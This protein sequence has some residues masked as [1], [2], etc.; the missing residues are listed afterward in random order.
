MKT[1]FKTL[2]SLIFISTSAIAQPETYT[3]QQSIELALTNNLQLKQTDLQAQ[4][5]TVN[6]KQ[7]RANLLP[8]VSA[9][10]GHGSNQGRSID[11]FTNAYA[12]K[13]IDYANY[14]LNG[15]ITLFSGLILRNQL[16]QNS[17]ALEASKMDLQQAKENLALDVILAY[18]QILNNQ[19]QLNQ[20]ELQVDVTS[21]QVERSKLLSKE[22]VIAPAQLSDLMGQL[23]ND[24]LSVINSRNRFDASRI[25][26]AGLMNVE[27]NRDFK[28]EPLSPDALKPADYIGPD[29]IY[30]LALQQLA[31]IR[32]A[33][34]R[35]ESAKKAVHAARGNLYPQI[36][37]N[38]N[39]FSNYSSAAQTS[40]MISSEDLPGSDYVELNGNKL[41]VISTQRS[42]E[43]RRIAYNSQIR[44]NYSSSVSIG[45]RMPLFN[46]SRVRNQISLAKIDLNST[47]LTEESTRLQLK[48]AVDLAWF[49]I[50]ASSN[51]VEI[52]TRQVASFSQSFRAAEARFNAGAGTVV[53]YTIAKNNLDQANINLINA[54]YEYL[55]RSKILDYYEGKLSF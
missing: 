51:K 14:S 23:A 9:N 35:T 38:S 37:L 53:D 30:S 8:G 47:Q 39:I 22:G 54:R 16:K 31:Q 34:L 11:P 48:Q 4:S 17:Y 29:K 24:E 6:L 1:I 12:N 36:T 55:L 32:G 27:Y 33:A 43:N 46:A 28:I 25:A 10:I 50:T 52:L 42:F 18:F 45:I 7:A 21:K 41:P 13:N 40:R 49:N 20:A 15:G 19:D 44:N 2:A 3:L 26:M 5:S